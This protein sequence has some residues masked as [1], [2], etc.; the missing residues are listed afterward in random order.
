M[1]MF[2]SAEA[3]R[4]VLVSGTNRVVV[5]YV[6]ADSLEDDVSFEDTDEGRWAARVIWPK[7]DE[8]RKQ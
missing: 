7:F 3:L 6:Q 1:A 5:A 8:L 4:I 2:S